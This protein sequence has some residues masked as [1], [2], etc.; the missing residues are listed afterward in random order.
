VTQ[1]TAERSGLDK[2]FGIRVL[3]RWGGTRTLR[4]IALVALVAGM[5]WVVGESRPWSGP[6]VTWVHDAQYYY[7]AGERLNHGTQLYAYSPGDRRLD[8]DPFY[9]AGP[10]LYPPL[11]GVVWRPIAQLLPFEIAVTVFWAVGLVVF[12]GTVC[13][14]LLRGGAVTALGVLMLLVPL[15][16]TAWSGNVSTLLTPLMIAS[17]LLLLRGRERA[18]GAAIG[19]AMVAKLTP[20]FL[21]WWLIVFRRWSAV[22][23]AIVAALLGL[24]LSVLGA[25]IESLP[26]YLRVSTLVARNGGTIASVTSILANLGAEPNVRVLVA[27]AISVV[28]VVAIVAL[29]RRPRAAWAVAIATGVFASPVFNLTNVS[30]LLAAFVALD[31]AFGPLPAAWNRSAAHNG[32]DGERGDDIASATLSA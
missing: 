18:A 27:P 13:W 1:P 6:P 32:A 20:A 24:A 30:L 8:V 5:A 17:W 11:L 29:R 4:V 14:L 23:T 2:V 10:F 25:G 12:L 7:G 9:F 16:W 3:V 15:V 21:G 26:D 19:V 31:P 22:Q 28:G